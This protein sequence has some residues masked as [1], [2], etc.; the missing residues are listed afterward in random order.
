VILINP[1][2]GKPV[3]VADAFVG[4]LLEAGFTEPEKKAGDAPKR[5]GRP[6]KSE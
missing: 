6:R 2:T 1:N 3:D 4:R 5:R